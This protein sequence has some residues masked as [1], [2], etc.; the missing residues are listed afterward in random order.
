MP[1]G[2]CDAQGRQRSVCGSI[3]ST[4]AASPGP[5]SAAPKNQLFGHFLAQ[6]SATFWPSFRRK[7]GTVLRAGF[8]ARN[9]GPPPFGKCIARSNFEAQIPGS[10]IGPRLEPKMVKKIE[11]WGNFFGHSRHG[12]DAVSIQFSAHPLA[13]ASQAPGPSLLGFNLGGRSSCTWNFI[14]W[15]KVFRLLGNG[16]AG[17]SL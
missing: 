9:L 16:S 12:S 7:L 3:H 11:F 1:G 10:K 14:F 8:W 13:L 17:Q 6:F 15:N 5:V 4:T 2:D